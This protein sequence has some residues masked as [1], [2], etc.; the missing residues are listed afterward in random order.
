VEKKKIRVT[1]IKYYKGCK[2]QELVQ[3]SIVIDFDKINDFKN[4]MQKD[5]LVIY[6]IYSEVK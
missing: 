5:E 4:V 6:L 3:C 1:E 2:M